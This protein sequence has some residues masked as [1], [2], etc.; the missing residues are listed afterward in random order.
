MF[1]RCDQNRNSWRIKISLEGYF[2]KKL[3]QEIW[4]RNLRKTT[5]P[6]MR[7][8]RLMETILMVL[9]EQIEE[10]DQ[11]NAAGEIAGSTPETSL[12]CE[13]ILKERGG[14]QEMSLKIWC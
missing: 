11:M 8:P 14:F 9:L 5:L 6:N 13:Q 2:E 10:D 1:R 4:D 7:N 3:A 12:E